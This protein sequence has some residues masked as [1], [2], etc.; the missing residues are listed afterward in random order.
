MD[1]RLWTFQT[2]PNHLLWSVIWFAITRWKFGSIYNDFWCLREADF[3]ISYGEIRWGHGGSENQIPEHIVSQNVSKW[4][5]MHQLSVTIAFVRVWDSIWMVY[6]SKMRL[7]GFLHM[8]RRNEWFQ[9]PT[10][11]SISYPQMLPNL[12][13]WISISIN[14]DYFEYVETIFRKFQ[15][16]FIFFVKV[17][18][19]RGQ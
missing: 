6:C 3:S 2:H 18:S 8:I 19:R 5:L 11:Q 16:F 1:L 15:I 14:K 9:K 12:F 7:R 10:F 13:I 4:V 17:V